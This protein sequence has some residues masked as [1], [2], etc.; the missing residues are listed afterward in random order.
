VNGSA[1]AALARA[2][3][4][5]GVG[6]ATMSGADRWKGGGAVGSFSPLCTGQREGPGWLVGRE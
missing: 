6:F 3:V 4:A 2:G 1:V 5:F